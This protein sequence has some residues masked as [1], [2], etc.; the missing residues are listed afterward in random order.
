MRSH[1]GIS[2]YNKIC[3]V[4]Q[5]KKLKMIGAAVFI[6]AIISLFACTPNEE[7][8]WDNGSVGEWDGTPT[9]VLE[10]PIQ[11][12]LRSTER[13]PIA[14]QNTRLY[15]Q[16]GKWRI[17]LE[18]RPEYQGRARDLDVQIKGE[19]PTALMEA[20]TLADIYIMIQGYHKFINDPKCET[21]KPTSLA[22]LTHNGQGWVEL[23]QQGQLVNVVITEMEMFH[24][25]HCFG[26]ALREAV[27]N[28]SGPHLPE[29][30]RSPI[31]VADSLN[32]ARM[33]PG[34]SYPELPIDPTE[35]FMPNMS[36]WRA[37]PNHPSIEL[38]EGKLNQTTGQFEYDYTQEPLQGQFYRRDPRNNP[39]QIRNGDQVMIRLSNG[40]FTK[41][42]IPEAGKN[43]GKGDDVSYNIFSTNKNGNNS[44]YTDDFNQIPEPRFTG[45]KVLRYGN[46]SFAPYS[47]INKNDIG[48]TS[49]KQRLYETEFAI[50]EERIDIPANIQMDMRFTKKT[51][52]INADIRETV[53]VHTIDGATPNTSTMQIGQLFDIWPKVEGVSDAN[54][55]PTSL[56]RVNGNRFLRLNVD[57]DLLQRELDNPTG[58]RVFYDSIPFGINGVDGYQVLELTVPTN[59]DD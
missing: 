55:N 43:H 29:I 57:G 44:L 26:S 7:R 36:E 35:P 6:T 52:Q 15:R 23:N 32:G 20:D 3:L 12:S 11:V 37:I 42:E 18:W 53:N 33:I 25:K 48:Y 41:I 19:M 34:N 58:A 2:R 54:F 31:A 21:D 4:K 40:K 13:E 14:V 5:A 9:P 46:Y 56:T 16:D 30:L 10:T 27:F 28:H 24:V 51:S 49:H 50:L 38:W 39:R 47:L 59:D 8:T 1:C 22:N 17:N 45:D